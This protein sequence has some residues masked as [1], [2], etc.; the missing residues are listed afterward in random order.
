MEHKSAEETT[1]SRGL[2]APADALRGVLNV[3]WLQ[4]V[5]Y[6]L[7]GQFRKGVHGRRRHWEE[8][9]VLEAGYAV[10]EQIRLGPGTSS[11]QV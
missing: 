11:V 6:V 3:V 7:G 10:A 8:Q 9:D 5:L 1:V 2:P 4:D